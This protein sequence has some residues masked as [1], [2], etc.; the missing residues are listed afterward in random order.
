MTRV[1]LLSPDAA[2][3]LAKRLVANHP[4]PGANHAVL[5]ELLD[6]GEIRKM[7]S[8]E[9]LCNEG[10]PGNEMWFLLRGSIKVQRKDMG[11]IVRDLC[12][13]QAPALI[14][15]MAVIDRSPRSASCV[16]E[17]EVELV[18]LT[19]DI[20][21]RLMTETSPTGSVLRRLLLSSLCG[22]LAQANSQVRELV[23][24][25]TV[26]EP[27]PTPV[28]ETTAQTKPMKPA[29]DM[30]EDSVVRLTAKLSGWDTDLTELEELE[31]EIELVVD[32]DQ[33]RRRD[34]RIVR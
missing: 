3:R 8:D 17:G 32:E 18:A 5:E 4:F 28:P 19:T 1:G 21:D 34:K 14:G 23:D 16:S 24:E 9:R 25:L 10:D 6:R 15:H 30:T 2:D 27:V 29:R 11:G 33:K 20:Y 7:S 12:T 22:Q 13:I 31:Q 26:D